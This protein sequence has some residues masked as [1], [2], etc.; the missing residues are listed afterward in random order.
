L[1]L[2]LKL[3]IDSLSI[4]FRKEVML[5]DALALLVMPVLPITKKTR[6]NYQGSYNRYLAPTLGHKDIL[7]IT[8]D[9]VLAAIKDA[10]PQS[11]YQA[12]MVG[13]SLMREAKS[14][15]L[16]TTVVTDSCK[17][18]TITVGQTRFLTWDQLADVNLGKYSEQIKFLALHGLRWGEAVALRQEDIYD[19]LVHINKSVHGATKTKAGVRVVPYV[20]HF[21]KFPKT[22]KPLAKILNA[23]GVNI[24]SLRKTYAYVLK[25]NGVHVTTAQRL[26]GHASPMVTL[27]IYTAVLDDEIISTGKILIDKYIKKVVA[28]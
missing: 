22:R 12:L 18:P 11:A 26:M 27:G 25:S 6:S 3:I 28:V 23:H 1:V 10:P 14:R 24:H 8:A 17:L 20:G 13:K 15:N 16:I 7:L 19:G 4:G 9:D 2:I 21:K 5:F